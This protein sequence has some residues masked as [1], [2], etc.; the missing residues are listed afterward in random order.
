MTWQPIMEVVNSLAE[1]KALG[2]QRT[3]SKEPV[4]VHPT[5]STEE[6]SNTSQTPPMP[7]SK[8]ILSS[9]IPKI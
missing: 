6:T 4:T 1:K 3:S 2:T 7:A 9:T 5:A 8:R